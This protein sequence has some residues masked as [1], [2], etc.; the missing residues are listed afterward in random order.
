M[1]KLDFTRKNTSCIKIYFV[2]NKLL[3]NKFCN[4]NKPFNVH[5]KMNNNTNPQS[6]KPH[7]TNPQTPN[8]Q[9]ANPQTH[10][11][12]GLIEFVGLGFVHLWFVGL[13]FVDLGFVSLGF[14]CLGFMS[15]GFVGLGFVNLWFVSLG[16]VHLLFVSLGFV[17]G[18]SELSLKTL[19]S[20]GE[21]FQDLKNSCNL[22]ISNFNILKKKKY[23]SKLEW[24]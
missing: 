20:R 2:I 8:P 6:R 18:L 15:L 22:K 14:V 5:K 13:E 23:L 19:W 16:F 4:F 11:V 17:Y 9:T 1:P 24:I 3:N 12:C 21:G 7:S 10:S